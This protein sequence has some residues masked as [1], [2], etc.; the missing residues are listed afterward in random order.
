MSRKRSGDEVVNKS[1]RPKFAGANQD[2]FDEM[3]DFVYRDN[4]FCLEK[5]A[6]QHQALFLRPTQMGKTSL[7]TLANVI[8]NKN[9]SQELTVAFQPHDAKS[10]FVLSIDFLEVAGAGDAQTVDGEVRECV[11]SSVND[12]LTLNPELQKHYDEPT[13]APSCD[14]YIVA[15][16]KAVSAY[17]LS[18]EVNERQSFLVLVDE[19]DKPV[20]EL[21]LDFIGEGDGSRWRGAKADLKNYRAFFTSCKIIA[22]GGFKKKNQ[23][24]QQAK[25][26]V[27]GVLPIAL[28]LISDF[29][30]EV[31]TFRPIFADAI[32][33]L[34]EDVDR[35]LD[36][37]D[38][39]FPF[40]DGGQEK[41]RVR[42]AIGKLANR[43]YFVS[44]TPLYH[45][46]M[47]NSMMNAL[48]TDQSRSAW[49][50]NLSVLP[51]G[52]EFQHIP[53][54]VYDVIQKQ[55]ALRGIARDLSL[56]K[57]IISDLKETLDL[58]DVLHDPMRPADYLTLLVHLGIASV[59][60]IR[61][62]MVFQATSTY[63]RIPFFTRLL[64]N[65]LQPLFDA[66]SLNALY[67]I[68]ATQIGEF[69]QTLPKSG[70][71]SL[72][73][74]AEKAR[75][76]RILELQFQGFLIGE[77][78][79]LLWSEDVA[80]TQEDVMNSGRTDV[81]VAGK[82][83]VLLLE[84]K[85]KPTTAGPSSAEMTNYHRQLHKYM[86]ELVQSENVNPAP[87]RRRVAGFVVVM[88]NNGKSFKVERTS[89]SQA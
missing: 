74:W 35:M 68:G 11:K 27:T 5:L 37:V 36:A 17:G 55:S 9:D 54:T 46:K 48:L 66:E 40:R 77:L 39:Y 67:L 45:T 76:N 42:A 33:L 49:L 80:T 13:G 1:R 24:L 43:L 60:E 56:N 12:F 44:E 86:E 85:Q 31:F 69:M 83:T 75:S 19:Y 78:A 14:K 16:A 59:R 26:W 72:V 64:E 61:G 52:T 51:V 2:V 25:V 87:V 29:N 82:G 81:R 28:K 38:G 62:R 53:P 50:R 32:G 70:M 71:S 73:R 21:L 41:A 20:R 84:L 3:A 6:S 89:Y 88:Y 10:M 7:L 63:F 58:G 30:P 57:E 22:A 15:A 18:K 65:S 79:N 34:D 8:Y 4:S 47:V 23:G